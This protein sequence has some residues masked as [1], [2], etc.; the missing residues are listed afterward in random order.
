MRLLNRADIQH[1]FAVTPIEPLRE[2][3]FLKRVIAQ[4]NE[5]SEEDVA[6]LGGDHQLLNDYQN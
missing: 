6:N 4:A 3:H 1:I 2:K 5:D